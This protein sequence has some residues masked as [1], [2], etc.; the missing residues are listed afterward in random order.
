[1]T[2]G[3]VNISRD[4]F[5]HCAFRDAPFSEREAWLWIIMEAAWKPRQRR[6]GHIVISIDR[7]QL[8]VSVRFMAEAWGWTAAKVQRYVERLKKLEMICAETDTG[9][10]VIT[11][12]NYDKF[13]TKAKATD[14]GPIQGR[15]RADTNENKDEIRKEGEE[16]EEGK[17]S[18]KKAIGERLSVDWFLPMDW[19]EWALNEGLSKDQIRTQADTFKDY[20]IAQPGAKGRKTD[21]QATW[22]NWIRK[23]RE[24]ENGNGYSKASGAANSDAA[25]RQIAIA[26]RFARSPGLNDF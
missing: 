15:Y 26:A 2:A 25:A 18:S 22:R 7:G 12:C 24:R 1:M 23:S 13:Q 5:D 6:V 20:W 3:T 11:V 14:T 17:P 21:W 8:A 19:G 10:T 16:K 9:L 4:L